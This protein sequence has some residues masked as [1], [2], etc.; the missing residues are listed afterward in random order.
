MQEKTE[1]HLAW[2][3][4]AIRFQRHPPG[5][6]FVRSFETGALKR[7]HNQMV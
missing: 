6:E 3:R 1:E 5:P 4:H 2:H 7:A